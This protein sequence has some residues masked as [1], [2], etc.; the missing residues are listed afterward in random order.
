MLEF[1]RPLIEISVD[2]KPK[3]ISELHLFTPMLDTR[4]TLTRNIHEAHKP[5]LTIDCASSFIVSLN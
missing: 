5:D 4:F 3:S 2:L 1:G